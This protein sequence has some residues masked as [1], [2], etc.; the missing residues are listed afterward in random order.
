MIVKN[1]EDYEFEDCL[2][3]AQCKEC[4]STLNWEANFDADGTQYFAYCCNLQYVM[5]P[6]NVWVAIYENNGEDYE[7]ENE[8]D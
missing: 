1:E 3:K 4:E 6:K 8:E 5:S 2:Y 7:D